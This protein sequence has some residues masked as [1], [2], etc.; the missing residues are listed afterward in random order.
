MARR[1]LITAATLIP[2]P[3]KKGWS[4]LWH[5]ACI[6]GVATATQACGSQSCR[7]A[8]DRGRNR[9][10]FCKGPAKRGIDEVR[11]RLR[12]KSL[13]RLATSQPDVAWKTE[14]TPQQASL[15][16]TSQG[17]P[18]SPVLFECCKIEQVRLFATESIWGSV[19]ERQPPRTPRECGEKVAS[20][21]LRVARKGGC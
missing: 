9:E 13:R 3:P 20:C 17:I 14:R 15:G 7:N 10:E 12:G 4:P 21:E 19:G 2:A 5:T 8:I 6:K 1:E 16:S 18:G 11:N